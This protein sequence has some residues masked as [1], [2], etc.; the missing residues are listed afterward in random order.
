MR[1]R[2]SWTAV[3]GQGEGLRGEGRS[4]EASAGAQPGRGQDGAARGP[5]A[6]CCC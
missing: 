2:E 3:E 4:A 1:R 5:R 6:A